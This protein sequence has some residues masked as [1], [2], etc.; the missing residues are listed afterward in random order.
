MNVASYWGKDLLEGPQNFFRLSTGVAPSFGFFRMRASDVYYVLTTQGGAAGTLAFDD[1]EHVLT[2][3]NIYL[4]KSSSVAE[5]GDDICDIVLADERILWQFT[6]GTADFNTYKTDRTTGTGEFELENL[7]SGSE[8]TFTEVRD[9]LKSILGITTLNFLSPTRKPRNII[10]TNV[11][12]TCIM[13]QFLIAA[14]SYLAVDLTSFPPVYSIFPIGDTEQSADTALI[15]LYTG[16][17][18]KSSTI[19]VNP[20]VQRGGT[21]KMLAAANPDSAPGRLLTYGNQSVSGGTGLHY[22]PSDYAVFGN[23][24]NDTLLV[25]IGDEVASEYAAS[26]ANI[27]RDSVYVGNLPFVLNRAIHEITWTQNA[28]GALTRVRA[29]RPHEQLTEQELQDTLFTYRRYLLGAGGEGTN[30]RSAKIQAGGVPANNT[31][32]YTCKLLDDGGNETGATIDVYPREH[33]GSN[34]LDSGD[35]HP[36]LAA[37]DIIAIFQD[38]DNVWYT[39][40]VFEDTIDC[41]CTAP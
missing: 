31:G 26:F 13:K 8:W 30:V 22:A 34:N 29:F 20:K 6:Y 18:H 11:P 16:L 19:L 37:A 10:G 23:E 32:P 15:T 36:N 4:V 9:A 17:L 1:G 2:L 35:I 5:L 12:G 25:T 33:L 7:N 27:W 41:V 14:Q 3:N 28:Q 38:L 40:C 24:E 39:T 21:A